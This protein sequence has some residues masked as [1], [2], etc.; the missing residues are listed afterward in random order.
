M[1]NNDDKGRVYQTCKFHDF[2]DRGI[3]AKCGHLVKMPSFIKQARGHI[4]LND[5]ELRHVYV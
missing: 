1:Y 3:C 2:W 4:L 5:K